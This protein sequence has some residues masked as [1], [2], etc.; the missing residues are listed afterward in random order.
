MVKTKILALYL[1]ISFV[2][3]VLA[4]S[5]TNS[6]DLGG[7]ST[8]GLTAE[9]A[10]L[11]G[12]LDIDNAMN[13]L[14][15]ISSLGERIAGT[16]EELFA[17]QYVYDKMSEMSMDEVTMESF[18]TTSWE[19]EGDS[20]RIVSPTL[21]EIPC[22]AYG[23]G[24][25]IWGRWFGQRYSFG[26][27]KGGKTLVAPVVDVGYG[28]AEEFAALG[29]LNG[30]IA[31]VMRDDN[32]QA[33][34]NTMTEEAALHGASAI[35]NYGYYGGIAHPDAIK[36]DVSGGPIPEFAISKNSAWHIQ[37]LL[38][39]GPVILEMEGRADAVSE[40]KGESVNV[41]GYMYGTTHPDEYIIFS[42]HIDCWWNGTNDDSSSIAA[43]LE[44]ARM[45]SEAREAGNFINERTLVFLS[46]GAEEFG[47]PWNTWYDWL[48]GSYEFVVAHPEIMEGLVINLNMDGV[49]FKK[50]T[51]RYWVE[52]TWEI[53]GFIANAIGDIGKT[54]QISYY[55]PIWS[56]TDAWSFG[57]KAGG[58]TAQVMWAAGF[59]PIYHTQLDNMD[60]ADEE[61]MQNVLQLY[62]LL[63]IRATHAIVM[64]FDFMP[65]VNWAASYLGAEEF[66]VPYEAESFANANTALDQL[67]EQ[68]AAI[69]VYAEQLKS[70]YEMAETDE[71]RA[72][73][74][75]EADALNGV[76]IDARRAITPWTL[77]EG[78]TMGSWDVFLRS[79]QHVNDLGYIDAAISKLSTGQ[80]QIHMAMS[81]LENVYS[82]EWGH[83]FS[84]EVYHAVM[85][86]M[87]NDA[88]YWADDFDQQQAY[89]DVHWIYMD[90]KDGALSIEDAINALEEI[91][92]TQL[93]PWLRE[94]LTTLDWA[95]TEA[96]N[97][98][99]SA[100]S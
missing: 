72:T 27:K 76:M 46:V 71:D 21:E 79:D 93:I 50:T 85:D 1:M 73:I 51:G 98:L 66:T 20:I 87:I 55:N 25:S 13:E 7:G 3:V 24:Y 68:V 30:A 40:E 42:G 6:L 39:N 31:L 23:Y 38:M 64:P 83:L 80:G 69:N 44:F 15:Y 94:D 56:W 89:V 88:M 75:A 12:S 91:R 53:N 63:A 26:N 10:A 97:V 82:M 16:E 52:N 78:G 86:W 14:D 28:T 41:A 37:D 5:T 19:H 34:P 32:L 95:W 70:A 17:Q 45:F 59:D 67:R 100:L 60:L 62:G 74:R 84:P 61:P 22:A 35:I 29:D 33:W 81:A 57:A 99:E 65:T 4:P 36:Q 18:P 90:L 47:G 96:A 43:V 8:S 58:S 54:G 77:G 48:I 9:E 11:L 92:T 49:S 2:A